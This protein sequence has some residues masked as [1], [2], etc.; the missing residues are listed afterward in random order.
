MGGKSDEDL[1]G[2]EEVLTDSLSADIV[3]TTAMESKKLSDRQLYSNKSIEELE[4]DYEK[5]TSERDSIIW[6]IV[7]IDSAIAGKPIPKTKKQKEAVVSAYETEKQ[8]ATSDT[9]ETDDKHD[10]DIESGM[11][12][13]TI[14]TDE[15]EAEN[16]D[17]LQTPPEE[18]EE[19]EQVSP[20]TSIIDSE[21]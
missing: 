17:E 21:N 4:N 11:P 20:D 2:K 5:L 6:E 9:T 8:V 7:K 16:P 15:P 3:D 14:D 1:T 18:N 10:N 13:D 19:R 12:M